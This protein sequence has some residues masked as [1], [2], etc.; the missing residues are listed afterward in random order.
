MKNLKYVVFVLIFALTMNTAMAND[1]KV[2]VVNLTQVVEASTQVKALKLEQQAKLKQLEAWLV[3]VKSDV[4]KQ[5]TKENREKLIKKYD[6][7]FVKKQN[8]IKAAYSKKL[9][10]IDKSISEVIAKDAAAKGYNLVLPK[11][12]VLF[13]GEDITS[14]II[15]KV[16]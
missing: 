2:A 12:T 13:G 14:D 10:D 1:Y 16:K 6:V 11:G 15:K 8:E 3:T 4:E 5:K 9:N 7:E